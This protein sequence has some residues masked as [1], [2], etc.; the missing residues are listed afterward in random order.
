MTKAL[1]LNFRVG[2]VGG[3]ILQVPATQESSEI[4]ALTPLDRGT[5]CRSLAGQ[6]ILFAV[7][8]YNNSQAEAVCTLSR[9]AE[10]LKLP[11]SAK[12]IGIL[13]PGDSKAGF[14]SYPVEKP[15]ANYVG[16][17]LAAFCN[18]YLTGTASL[19]FVSHS[20]GARVAL[21]TIRGLDRD[22]RSLCLM[23]AAIE[24]HCLEK[25]YAYAF[26]KTEKVY[27]LASAQDP[28]LRYAF[29]FGNFFGHLLDPTSNPLANALGFSGPKMA[30][31]KLTKPWQIKADDNYDHGSYMPSSEAKEFPPVKPDP[32]DDTYRDAIKYIEATNF[33][34]RAFNLGRQTWPVPG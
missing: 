21:E 14:I 29:P 18:R 31:G 4:F 2:Q 27:V 20:L 32:I 9:L 23:A 5:F 12:F 34:R 15:T 13:W 33:V 8:G 25:E 17:Y 24:R 19:S 3:G 28:V 11:T 22:T 30:S 16:R 7:H 6:D 1:F 26:E 10:A